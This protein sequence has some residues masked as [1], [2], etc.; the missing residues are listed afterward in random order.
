MYTTRLRRRG[1]TRVGPRWSYEKRKPKQHPIGMTSDGYGGA[2]DT[3]R[4][5][6]SPADWISP[7]PDRD[8]YKGNP[9]AATGA[10]VVILDTDHLWGVGGGRDVV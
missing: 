9:P 6:D 4:L 5:F 2:D 8:D 3:D 1:Y 7:S 10:K